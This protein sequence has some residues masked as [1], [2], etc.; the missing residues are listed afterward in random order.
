MKKSSKIFWGLYFIVAAIAIV[1]YQMDYFAETNLISL[2]FVV[3]TIPIVIM[4]L[5]K[6]QWAGVLF[7]IAILLLMF[8]ETLGMPDLSTWPV[9]A[10]AFF[11]T[12]GL[13][14]IFTPK[15]L[16]FEF[17]FNGDFE[18]IEDILD[19]NIINCALSFSSTTKYVNTDNFERANFK[20]SFGELKVYFDNAKVNENGAI[21]NLDLSFSGAELFIPKEWNIVNKCDSV[22]SGIDE[23]HHRGRYCDK[24]APLVII[25]GNIYF[26]GVDINY[27]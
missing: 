21:I 23:N 6:F 11:G 1:L 22:L 20:C 25:T 8:D 5:L 13:S 10:V 19:D 26:S 16:Q 2:I 27:I 3:L 14:F 4:S 15:L 17:G 24:N 18:N 7:P 12:I 9:L